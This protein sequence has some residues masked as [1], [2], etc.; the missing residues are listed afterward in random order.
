[1]AGDATLA[2]IRDKADRLERTLRLQ[3]R[4]ELPA[5]VAAAL[6]SADPSTEGGAIERLVTLRIAYREWYARESGQMRESDDAEGLMLQL[7]DRT[8]VRVRIS[9]GRVVEITGRSVAALIQLS[10]QEARLA[11]LQV[12]IEEVRA[13]YQRALRHARKAPSGNL[14][15]GWRTYAETVQAA[16]TEL[17]TALLRHRER[18]C[19]HLATPDGAPARLEDPAPEWWR[20]LTPEDD[21][22]LILACH[23]AGPE[24]ISRASQALAKKQGGGGAPLAF[25]RL[26]GAYARALR[27]QP[28]AL[29]SK[30]FGQIWAEV[31]SLPQH[32]AA[33]YEEALDDDA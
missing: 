1:V 18:L 4:G 15:R 17:H 29:M 21:A 24:R 9:S 20:E 6:E 11:L 27:V 22:L 28:A 23:H 13:R 12:K 33:G 10:G 8:P 3:F 31:E 14:R 32:A 25:H 19:A 7:I 5:G 2:R 16:Y 26:L 30:D